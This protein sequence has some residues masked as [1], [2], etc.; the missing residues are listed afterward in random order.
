MPN[1]EF[2]IASALAPFD[3]EDEAR[4]C[5]F[6]ATCERQRRERQI[7]SFGLYISEKG[8]KVCVVTLEAQVIEGDGQTVSAAVRQLSAKL[9]TA[10]AAGT[11]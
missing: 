4:L 3:G 1:T 6:L 10:G 8:V 7:M 2:T 11:A 9:L 5:A